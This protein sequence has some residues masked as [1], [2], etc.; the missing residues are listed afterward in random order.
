MEWFRRLFGSSKT[1]DSLAP[2]T[3]RISLNDP[4]IITTPRIGL[5]N[6]LGSSA[7]TILEEDKASFVPLFPR[8]EESQ[9]DP[10][11]CDVLMIYACVEA[12]GRI[13]GSAESLRGLIRKSRA[14]IVIVA[15]EN[16]GENYI[17]AGKESSEAKA[18]LV[19]TLKRKGPVFGQFFGELFRRMFEGQT[20]PLAWVELAPQN[21][22]AKHDNCP[23][24]I[25]AAEVSHIIFRR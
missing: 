2:A 20:M 16:P 15:N 8:S 25:F 5:L 19:M 13:A 9:S 21:R 23:E 14:P 24:S 12:D 6:L 7:Q 17:A 22:N 10:P 4:L 3:R 18:N 1:A 11:I